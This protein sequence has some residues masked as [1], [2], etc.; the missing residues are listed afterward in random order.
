MVVSFPVV[1]APEVLFGL[2]CILD[3]APYPECWPAGQQ[4]G[5]GLLRAVSTVARRY[6]RAHLADVEVARVCERTVA[7][8][9]MREAELAAAECAWH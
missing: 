3:N 2:G 4:P 7:L 6:I 5:P 1:T 9:D 8:A